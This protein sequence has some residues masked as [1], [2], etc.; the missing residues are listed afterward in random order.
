MAETN[1]PPSAL[2]L[3]SFL[4]RG[5]R[6]PESGTSP[7]FLIDA[8]DVDFRIQGILTSASDEV[9]QV[10]GTKYIIGT[11]P[12][13]IPTDITS[14][15]APMTQANIVK[16]DIVQYNDNIAKWELYF[17]SNAE[18]A[19]AS[20]G[21]LVYSYNNN[22]FYG[23]NGT[24]W[25]VIGSGTTGDT[26][27]TGHTG[28]GSTGAGAGFRYLT[29]TSLEPGD[30]GLTYSSTLTHGL[31][32]NNEPVGGGNTGINSIFYPVGGQEASPVTILIQSDQNPSNQLILRTKIKTGQET[33]ERIS[34]NTT[35]TDFLHVYYGKNT[36]D[37]IIAGTTCGVMIIPEGR[38][39]ATGPV[40][41][42]GATG[43][44]GGIAG[45]PYKIDTGVA[46]SN[47]EVQI[48]GFNNWNALAPS[49]NAFSIQSEDLGGIDHETLLDSF[50]NFGDNE[51]FWL[52][53]EDYY[54]PT[55]KF[56]EYRVVGPATNP[57]GG[58]YRWTK[59]QLEPL[60]RT[61]DDGQIWNNGE[62]ANVLLLKLPTGTTGAAGVN[63]ISGASGN[64]LGF[65]MKLRGGVTGAAVGSWFG[66]TGDKDNGGWTFGRHLD[67]DGNSGDIVYVKAEDVPNGEG[68]TYGDIINLAT[69]PR[70]KVAGAED[71]T[72]VAFGYAVASLLG[73]NAPRD[74]PGS[75]YFYKSNTIYDPP[76][77]TVAGIAK[78]RKTELWGKDADHLATLRLIGVTGTDVYPAN[79]TL[80][81][82]ENDDVLMH[83]V[84]DGATG[85]GITYGDT[86]DGE[87][88]LDYIAADGSTFGR[89]ATG[90]TG[91]SGDIGNTGPQ[92]DMNPF[93]IDYGMTFS[94]PNGQ[95]PNY[96]EDGPAGHSYDRGQMLYTRRNA[97]A[98]EFQIYVSKVDSS[99]ITYQGYL[100]QASEADTSNTGFA[101][102][103]SKT[104]ASKFGI[105]Q[106]GSATELPGSGG[107]ADGLTGTM[108]FD[109]VIWKAGSIDLF[110]GDD[111]ATQATDPTTFPAGTAVKFAINQ[112]GQIGNT[113]FGIGFTYGNEY[114]IG[115]NPPKSRGDGA[116][117]EIGDKW[118]SSTTGLEFTFLGSSRDDSD[119]G[120]V[121]GSDEINTTG[122]RKHVR[123]VQTNSGRRGRVGPH[124]SKGDTGADGVGVTGATGFKF[125][126][127][128]TSGNFTP[129]FY[130]PL[131]VVRM[132]RPTS[133]ADTLGWPSNAMEGLFINNSGGLIMNLPSF[134]PHP[135]SS[136]WS[137][138]LLGT[139]GPT[140]ADGTLGATGMTGFGFTGMTLDGCNLKVTKIDGNGQTIETVTIGNPCI[141]GDTGPTGPVAGTGYQIIHRHPGVEG[142]DAFPMGTN[143]LRMEAAESVFVGDRAVISNYREDVLVQSTA[144]YD[145]TTKR[146]KVN[147]MDK[148]V[149]AIRL[150]ENDVIRG[151]TLAEMSRQGS[152]KTIYIYQPTTLSSGVT[153]QWTAND[154]SNFS[155]R[156][157]SGGGDGESTPTIRSVYFSDQGNIAAGITLG[158][159]ANDMSA[160]HFMTMNV[161]EGSDNAPPQIDLLINHVPYYKRS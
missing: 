158:P 55:Q 16:G 155:V 62:R 120:V 68:A 134:E 59:S 153:A 80:K 140:G 128:W 154:A 96:G 1:Y 91:P 85:I 92:G 60:A 28:P 67:A 53:I 45:F 124:G 42:T 12:A 105:F 73:N 84:L 125:I 25:D 151:V 145:A 71:Y 95:V 112:D 44:T 29:S 98:D 9:V 157:T 37:G 123:W 97:I 23:F 126:G 17:S 137:V 7:V 6:N 51:S 88:F 76:R 58:Q 75:L 132:V 57:G 38:T 32:L 107:D 20:G 150:G 143:A 31:T 21:G 129:T 66:N 116:S 89:F 93:N 156:A 56:I 86:V 161:D 30:G 139:S 82:L 78:F 8:L 4:K 2:K 131:D 135:N 108:R 47:G 74:N 159:R 149:S 118:F 122:F 146:L 102:V 114:F 10:G 104:D 109:E 138:L 11:G 54:H 34:I 61:T 14:N 19:G 119:G 43:I 41:P 106:Y 48:E 36:F 46:D 40:G 72:Q 70:M 111:P 152:V 127:E 33:S 83:A 13:A 35:T 121:T 49:A 115:S 101:T 26:G 99:G 113:G 141:T 27:V 50:V 148:N 100:Q 79:A 147:G 117:F 22:N 52:R 64:D 3:G 110:H 87:L 69:T 144:I 81:L 133:G 103:F 65:D 130:N 24:E 142:G 136:F 18:N 77:F 15:I 39:G 90:I 5:N 160:L 63:G 94:I